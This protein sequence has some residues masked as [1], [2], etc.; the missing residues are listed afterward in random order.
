VLSR[1]QPAA[2]RT[3]TWDG[4]EKFHDAAEWIGYLIEHFLRRDACAQASGDPQFRGFTFDHV[5]NGR[6]LVQGEDPRDRWTL[7][8][9]D[10]D[11][12]VERGRHMVWVRC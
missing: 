12:L 5:L 8:V 6:V 4:H 7:V 2:A 10:N 11:V 3:I 9:A 1:P